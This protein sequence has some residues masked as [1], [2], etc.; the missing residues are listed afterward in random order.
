MSLK[1][2][3]KVS[4]SGL[5]YAALA[6][7]FG[8]FG[9]GLWQFSTC[10]VCDAATMI[11]QSTVAQNCTITATPSAGATNLSLT[12]TGA[13]HIEVG[14]VA[15]SC[16]NKNGYTLSLTS[17]NCAATPAG[18]KVSDSVS[19][20]YLSYSGEFINPTTGGSSADVMGLLASSC[21]AANGRDVT[22]AKIGNETSTLYVNFTGSATLA[23]GTYQDT[24]TISITMK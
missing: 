15:Q 14:T 17:A 18:A 4:K 23:A 9:I 22:N 24:L 3:W 12:T 7:L 11:L 21:A 10:D 2:R 8:G 19:G 13:Q 16:N 20:E 1:L 6:V 5:R